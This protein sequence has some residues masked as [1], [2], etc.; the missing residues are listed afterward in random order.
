MHTILVV[1]D[2]PLARQRVISLLKSYS[3]IQ[4]VGESR[5]GEEAVADIQSKK[6][7]LIFLDIE[8]PVMDGINTRLRHY[9]TVS[10]SC[11]RLGVRQVVIV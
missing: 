5:N 1:D 6:P 7:D 11:R 2:E 4:V 8:M 3:E 9:L 10:P